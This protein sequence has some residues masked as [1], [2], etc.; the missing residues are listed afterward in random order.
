MKFLFKWQLLGGHVH[1]QVF[2]REPPSETWQKNGELVFDEAGWHSLR[3]ILLTST[4]DKPVLRDSWWRL[5][6]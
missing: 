2:Q 5:E 6:L 1:V 3:G 4:F